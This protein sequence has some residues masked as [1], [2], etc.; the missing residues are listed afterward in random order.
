MRLPQFLLAATAALLATASSAAS[1]ASVN[2]QFSRDQGAQQTGGAVVGG[3]GDQWND[4]FG[5]TGSGTLFDAAGAD[6]GINLS[7]SAGLVY[8]SQLGYT[9]FTGT[10]YSNLMQGYLVGFMDSTPIDL[11]FSGL[12]AGQTYGFWIY[13][14]GDN[15]SAGRSI[16]LS[17]NGGD[18]A[19]A[20]QT[21]A[22][23][24]TLGDNYVYIVTHADAYGTVDIV[25]RDLNGEANINGVQLMAI[26]EPTSLALM[27]AGLLFAAGAA[28]RKRSR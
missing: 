19:I 11:K 3:A 10:P 14:Q 12:A 22:N 7:F 5:N 16:S 23:Q 6:T 21:N 28:A 25:G 27:A 2:V 1:A 9:Q 13:T 4:L 15:N 24:F 20:T 8:E 18:A 17:A 26:P